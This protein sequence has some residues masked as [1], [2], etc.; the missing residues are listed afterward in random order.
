MSR[1]VS[2]HSMQY[3]CQRHSMK[4][5]D[6]NVAKR[7]TQSQQLEYDDFLCCQLTLKKS[8]VCSELCL[9]YDSTALHDAEIEA[10]VDRWIKARICSTSN[11]ARLR[12]FEYIFVTLVLRQEKR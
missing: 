10:V 8:R 7:V 9:R 5:L 3:H 4:S 2:R 1:T 12:T 11:E 6:S